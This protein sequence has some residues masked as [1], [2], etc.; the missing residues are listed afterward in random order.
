MADTA[1]VPLLLATIHPA[2]QGAEGHFWSVVTNT[3][4]AKA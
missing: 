4:M 1:E 3:R 2:W